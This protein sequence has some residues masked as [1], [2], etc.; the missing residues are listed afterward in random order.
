[1]SV[2]EN[3]EATV[4]LAAGKIETP[5][6]APKEGVFAGEI[7]PQRLTLTKAM[8]AATAV[9]LVFGITFGILELKSESDYNNAPDQP[10]RDSITNTGRRNAT[11]ANVGFIGAGVCAVVAAIAGY[12]MVVKPTGEKSTT[13]SFVPVVGPGM[14][15]G[16]AALRF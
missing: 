12:P 5:G 6:G 1:V 3:E 8:V 15:G 9:T 4:D 13:V 7:S 2:A 16:V 14:A 10:S 11:L